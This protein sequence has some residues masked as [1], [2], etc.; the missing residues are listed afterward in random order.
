MNRCVKRDLEAIAWLAWAE[1]TQDNSHQRHHVALHITNATGLQPPQPDRPRVGPKRE[2]RALSEHVAR[3]A[4]HA[5][6]GSDPAP[7]DL[8]EGRLRRSVL[9]TTRRMCWSAIGALL[10]PKRTTI[11]STVPRRVRLAP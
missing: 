5:R 3:A 9:R 6:C 1:G 2:L 7:R 10:Q 11:F 8:E 4:A